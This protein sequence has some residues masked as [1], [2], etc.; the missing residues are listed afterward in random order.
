MPC[1]HNRLCHTR[2]W[3]RPCTRESAEGIPGGGTHTTHKPR[4]FPTRAGLYHLRDGNAPSVAHK[5]AQGSKEH[6]ESAR[7]DIIQGTKYLSRN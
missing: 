4:P 1:C 7:C 3:G 2:G 6:E 5:P